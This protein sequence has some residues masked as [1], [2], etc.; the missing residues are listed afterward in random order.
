[1]RRTARLFAL[2]EHLR[3]RRSG[4]VTAAQLAARFRVSVRTIYRDLDEL[5]D[6]ELPLLA[7][8]GRGGGYVLDRSYTLPPVNFDAREAALLI[9]A[10]EMLI[11]QRLLP[12]PETLRGALDKVRAALPRAAQ[13]DLGEV[14][15]G[16]SYVGVPARAP[17]PGVERAVERAWFERRSLRVAYTSEAGPRRRIVRIEG[18]VLDRRE[19]RLNC[20]DVETGERR[21]LTL[22]RLTAASVV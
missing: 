14:A 21:Q 17:A 15:R 8:G 10:G 22:H 16:V 13:R 18:V 7:E 3:A 5:R 9:T 2:A 20:V 19:T 4:G 1:M 12:F 11:E 6:G